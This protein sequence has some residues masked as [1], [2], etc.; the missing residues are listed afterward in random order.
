MSA[1]AT[2][3]SPFDGF[4]KLQSGGQ[5]KKRP[6]N[7]QIGYIISAVWGLPSASMR[8]GGGGGEGGARV[9]H[10]WGDWIQTPCCLRSPQR[11]TTGNKIRSG[12]QIGELAT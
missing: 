2:E 5:N 10:K 7:R 6:T 3:P 11:C 9:A 12:P 4:P 8:G 1:M